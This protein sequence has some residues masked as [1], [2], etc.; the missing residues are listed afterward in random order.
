MIYNKEFIWLHFPKAA[1]TKVEQIF[2]R[3]YSSDSSIH[4][5]DIKQL[6]PDGTAPW[7]DSIKERESYD[8]SFK[9]ENKTIIICIR[10]L[11]GWL[12]SRYNFEYKRS[13]YLEHNPENLLRGKFYEATGYL[14]EAD[15]YIRNFM[16]AELFQSNNV[17]FIRM[18]N[19]EEDFRKIFGNFIDVSK[20]PSSEFKKKSNSSVNYLSNDLLS[21]LTNKLK[22]HY[23]SYLRLRLS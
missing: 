5:D 6:R 2:E 7:H 19:F 14:N 23:K 16:P 11:K 8:P 12:K 20:V 13:S 9:S 3:Y 10:K 22:P 1:G 18:E 15:Q 21:N 17:V 4:Q